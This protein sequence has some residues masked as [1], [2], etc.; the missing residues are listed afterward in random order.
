MINKKRTIIK[1]SELFGDFRYHESSW[2]V[3]SWVAK[4]ENFLEVL[5]DVIACEVNEKKYQQPTTFEE[6]FSYLQARNYAV[7]DERFV[8]C[9]SQGRLVYLTNSG[10]SKVSA[11][12]DLFELENWR[13]LA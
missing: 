1:T 3:P 10:F 12:P 2:Q 5:K 13:V 11:T 8:V 7:F 6:L 4:N 9:L